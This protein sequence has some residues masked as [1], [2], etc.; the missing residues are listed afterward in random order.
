MESD[1]SKVEDSVVVYSP[2]YAFSGK[3]CAYSPNGKFVLFT[4][5]KQV[6]VMSVDSQFIDFTLFC[7]DRVDYAEWA[8]NSEYILCCVKR[9]NSIEVSIVNGCQL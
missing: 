8:P 1:S 4:N 9:S 2:V 7:S 6:S 5:G 3:S